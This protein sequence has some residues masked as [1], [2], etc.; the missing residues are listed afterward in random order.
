[1]SQYCAADG[2]PLEICWNAAYRLIDEHT[3]EASEVGRPTTRMVYAFTLRDGVLA[4]DVVNAD[5]PI[6]LIAQTAIFETLPFTR[7]P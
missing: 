4:L 1:M 6:D 5:D 7:V 3:I 2:G